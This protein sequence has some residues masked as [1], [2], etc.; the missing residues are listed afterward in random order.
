MFDVV[1]IPRLCYFYSFLI[2]QIGKVEGTVIST[3]KVLLKKMNRE[4]ASGKSMRLD[5]NRCWKIGKTVN[6]KSFPALPK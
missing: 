6:P 2:L 5:M 3:N 4:N 1:L